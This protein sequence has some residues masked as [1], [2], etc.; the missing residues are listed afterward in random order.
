MLIVDDNE[1]NR[2]AYRRALQSAGHFCQEA[3][4]GRAA[5][6]L[7]DTEF[8]VILLDI[9]MP[10]ESGLELLGSVHRV[11]PFS[12]VIMVTGEDDPQLA[13][14]AAEGGA[15]GYMV[16]PVRPSELVINVANA[17]HRRRLESAN[18]RIL[19]GLEQAVAARTRELASALAHLDKSQHEVA[20]SRTEVTLRVARVVESRDEATGRHI[21]RMS[22]NCGKIAAKLGFAKPR[23][24]LIRLASRLHDVGKVAIP[25]AILNKPGRLTAVE[26]EVM[27]GH[28]EAGYRILSDSQSDLVQLAAQIAWCHHERWDGS[29]YPRALAGE[30]IPV[31]GQIA[32]IADVFDALTSDRVYRRTLPRSQ[33]LARVRAQRGRHFNPEIVDAFLEAIEGAEE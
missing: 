6:A 16:K 7:L 33:A 1:L 24:E 4:D 32:A 22:A 9:N 28:A 31:E 21:E 14:K 20:A 29:G 26:F 27:K 5:R 2:Q 12:A 19:A 3:G 8:D 23:Q 13:A 15:Y 30:E 11:Q 17:L 10:G 18:R 25:D